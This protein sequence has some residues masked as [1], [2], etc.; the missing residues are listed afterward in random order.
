MTIAEERWAEIDAGAANGDER[1]RPYGAIVAWVMSL[2][3]IT[4]FLGYEGLAPL[5]ALA[6]LAAIP[7]LRPRRPPLGLLPLGLLVAWAVVSFAWSPLEP[8]VFALHR[9]EDFQNLT[10]VKLVMQAILYPCFVLAAIRIPSDWRATALLAL[11]V[12]VAALAILLLIEGADGQALFQRLSHVVGRDW[13]PDLARRQV[14]TACF[15]LALLFWPA[16]LMASR[17]G[18]AGGAALVYVAIGV[19]ALML[20]VASPLAALL[21]SLPVFLLVRAAG[22][23][24]VFVCLAGAIVYFLAAPLVAAAS[25]PVWNALPANAGKLSWHIRIDVWRFVGTLI[26]HHPLV[27]WGLDASR[28]WPD[29]VPMHPHD[30]AL[31]LWLETGAVGVALT[32]ALWTWLFLAIARL[33]R[34]DRTMSAGAA[35]TAAVYLVIGAVSFGVWQEWWLAA[36]ALALTACSAL[37][38]LRAQE[39]QEFTGDELGRFA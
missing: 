27:G 32:I 3:P 25:G 20:N 7:F 10:A 24:G 36:G 4:A 39:R 29:H 15:V 19:S 18:W 33:A 28:A 37:A 35:A 2:A 26:P 23:G 12:W 14:G 17:R 6:G 11:A 30:A 22:R 5:V 9:Y 21:V 16:A 1:L 31:Q 34:E 38:R 8:R 13:P